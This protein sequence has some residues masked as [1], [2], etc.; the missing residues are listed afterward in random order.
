MFMGLRPGA[1]PMVVGGGVSEGHLPGRS[2]L[3]GDMDP[4]EQTSWVS[5]HTARRDVC[6]MPL[7]FIS[8]S[9]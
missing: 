2:M 5:L 6:A 8:R 9:L 1:M 7:P 4:G 3:G